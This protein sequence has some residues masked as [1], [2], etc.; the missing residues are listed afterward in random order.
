M[1]QK[2][3]ETNTKKQEDKK[4]E[5]TNPKMVDLFYQDYF[6]KTKL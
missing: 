5:L 6:F 4:E 3:N 2:A 1:I